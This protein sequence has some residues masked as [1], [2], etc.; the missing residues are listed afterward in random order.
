MLVF[1]MNMY[2][3]VP[4]SFWRYS[5][6]SDKAGLNMD[7]NPGLS[8]AKTVLHQLSYQV[9]WELIVMWVD[10]KPVDDG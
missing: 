7:S 8:D 3:Y 2:I 6:C 10:H 1:G 9:N 5:S 4:R